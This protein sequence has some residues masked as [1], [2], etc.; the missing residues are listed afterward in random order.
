[1]TKNRTPTPVY[2]DPGM[3]SGLE[4]K[5][6]NMLK[7]QL[8]TKVFY[9]RKYKPVF[10][11]RMIWHSA[12]KVNFD[13]ESLK[14]I[15]LKYIVHVYKKYMYRYYTLSSLNI[16]FSS[17]ST[18]KTANFY[19]N[20]RLVGLVDEDNLM[21]VGNWRKCIGKPVSW[22][23]DSKTLGCSKMKSVFRD[24]KWCF[25]ASWGLKGLNMRHR[26]YY[27]IL[28]QQNYY[29]PPKTRWSHFTFVFVIV[30]FVFIFIILF[31]CMFIITPYVSYF[32]VYFKV[33]APLFDKIID[34][35]H[36]GYKPQDKH[37]TDLDYTKVK[38]Y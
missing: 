26:L 34:E 24:V 29:S 13:S 37:R 10:V 23:I 6:L 14:N 5:G 3:H 12:V 31:F 36:N 38:L 30:L 33:F 11:I 15:Q 27:I 28:I 25:D 19:R 4:V 7:R 35:R 22:K 1:M 8:N 9:H 18:K 16:P 20:S 17:S 32:F 21:W 2:L